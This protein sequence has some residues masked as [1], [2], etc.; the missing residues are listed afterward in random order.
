MN[1]K[2]FFLIIL[3][4][5]YFLNFELLPI[6]NKINEII[7]LKSNYYECINN[8]CNFNIFNTTYINDNNYSVTILGQNHTLIADDYKFININFA[9]TNKTFD[10][11]IIKIYTNSR[12][13]SF[14][15]CKFYKI[16]LNVDEI[17]KNND[18]FLNYE[19]IMDDLENFINEKKKKINYN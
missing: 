2:L 12:I 8:S 17:S 7:Y 19:E 16:I 11:Q 3:L 6:P 18:N 1:K 4:K 14:K 9:I 13:F 15:K 5:F 10:G